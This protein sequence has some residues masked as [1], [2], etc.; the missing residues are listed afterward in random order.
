MAN[1][2]TEEEIILIND[3]YLEIGVK[4]RVAEIVGRSA[5][6]VS[7][8]I[9]PGYVSQ[10]DKVAPPPFDTSKICDTVSIAATSWQEFAD[11]CRLTEQELISLHELQKE[12]MV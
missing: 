9:I 11:A 4:A 3:L 7:K 8:Y 2:V 6:T 1:K 5:S 10:K 12:L